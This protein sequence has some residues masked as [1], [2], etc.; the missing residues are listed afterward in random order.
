M[1]H[2]FDSRISF[3]VIL[4]SLN[5]PANV[6]FSLLLRIKILR[7]SHKFQLEKP[8]LST[9]S[10]LAQRVVLSMMSTQIKGRSQLWLLPPQPILFS[11]RLRLSHRCL[12]QASLSVF[13][14]V[15]GLSSAKS[16][17]TSTLSSSLWGTRPE[18]QLRPLPHHP[19]AGYIVLR[20]QH[21]M[22]MQGPLF[23]S[24]QG[25]GRGGREV[26]EGGDICTLM[27]ESC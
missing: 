24:Y 27:A 19:T 16:H 12:M 7:Q 10:P 25:M 1:V 4:Q 9:R 20:A 18:A 14:E 15:P 5:K 8:V 11:L 26:Q 21:K 6:S 22:K 13:P 3:L 17:P 23:Q 2:L